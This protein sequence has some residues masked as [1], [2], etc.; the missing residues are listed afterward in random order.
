MIDTLRLFF[1]DPFSFYLTTAVVGLI[2]LV[3]IIFH[4]DKNTPNLVTVI[5]V[6]GTFCGIT[7]GLFMF[8]TNNIEASVPSLL[9]GLKTAFI[10]SI[11][12]MA[13][14]VLL[15][16]YWKFLPQDTDQ[17]SEEHLF[18]ILR[19]L[20]ALSKQ[21][22]AKIEE[23]LERVENALV[24]E[25]DSTL[26]TQIQK[27]RTGMIDKQDEL[28]KAF[29]NFAEKMA[30]DNRSALIEALED[31]LRQFNESLNQHFRDNFKQ[32]NKG[33]ERLLEWQ[34]Q[35]KEHMEKLREEFESTAKGIEGIKENL[36]IAAENSKSF[37]EA[38][39]QLG[40]T[41]NLIREQQNNINA[42]L[43]EF[44]EIA[45]EAK[46]SIPT[47]NQEFEDARDRFMDML[48]EVKDTVEST[49]QK[50]LGAIKTQSD[51]LINTS[52]AV[53]E[54]TKKMMS[55][56]QSTAQKLLDKVAGDIN[57]HMVMIT[58]NIEEAHTHFN[59]SM[60]TLNQQQRDHIEEQ[61]LL[62]QNSVDE[63]NQKIRETLDKLSS[64][65]NNLMTRNGQIINE[66]IS[67]LDE[68]LGDELNKAMQ[69]FGAN[70]ASIS[71]RFSED[72]TPLADRLRKVVRI[73]EKVDGKHQR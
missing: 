33:V 24:G 48:D 47:I 66:Q 2:I 51:E 46:E 67:K 31:V 16:F 6:I 5:G 40:P 20:L 21:N 72:Y 58:E 37:V 18:S 73:A 49:T 36:E 8:D 35:Y 63:T 68:S 14:A 50:N 26:I 62:L 3:S 7:M 23:R 43:V 15:K 12:G 65:I 42:S 19:E 39:E 28:I 22:S 29:Q 70:L 25:G 69:S 4:K 41:L 11:T 17:S 71:N 57:E 60:T 27:M 13:C 56:Y 38:G 10:T 1:H 44:S 52:K 59:D 30:D 54:E 32:L 45:K 34:D 64:D 61:N 55:D 9:D 53:G